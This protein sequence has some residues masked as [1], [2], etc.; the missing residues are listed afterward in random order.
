MISKEFD[1]LEAEARDWLLRLNFTFDDLNR[2][3]LL[4]PLRNGCLLCELVSLLENMKLH[5][6][7]LVPENEKQAIE[8]IQKA[9][10]VLRKRTKIPQ[11][12]FEDPLEFYNGNPQ[13]M[14]PL[15][16][17]IK[18]EYPYAVPNNKAS[19]VVSSQVNK[20]HS[21]LG[22]YMYKN[23]LLQWIESLN[24]LSNFPKKE[25]SFDDIL[26]FLQQGTLLCDIV[27]TLENNEILG[28]FRPPRTKSTALSNIS[29]ALQILKVKP[30]MNQKWT[31]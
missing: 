11:E 21:F 17:H 15:L 5:R 10:I 9:F 8:N 24:L 4:D 27:S 29:K 1:P 2:N 18:R 23:A 19:S 31:R 22:V 26:P 20:I 3:A 16:V 30:G 6:V 14:W 13:I 12:F 7:H 28:V 25:V